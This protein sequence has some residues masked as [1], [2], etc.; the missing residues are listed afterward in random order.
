MERGEDVKV[1]SG[2]KRSMQ[3]NEDTRKGKEQQKDQKPR[4]Q[5]AWNSESHEK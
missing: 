2:K 1:R 5:E 3:G 4:K